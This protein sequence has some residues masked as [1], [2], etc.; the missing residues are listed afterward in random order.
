MA[1]VVEDKKILHVKLGKNYPA[2]AEIKQFSVQ[3]KAALPDYVILITPEYVDLNVVSGNDM[4]IQ[5]DD[6]GLTAD[7]L[8]KL[9]QQK[10]SETSR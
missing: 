4:L 8:A 9:V 6:V 2:A 3:L 1:D 7:D 10:V 5:V